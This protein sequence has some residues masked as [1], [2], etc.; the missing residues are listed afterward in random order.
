MS[1]RLPTSGA[2]RGGG[3]PRGRFRCG[4]G[5]RQKPVEPER[6]TA[7]SPMCSSTRWPPGRQADGP[8]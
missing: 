8:P 1:D 3:L 7:P 5:E 6:F 4:S 2:G